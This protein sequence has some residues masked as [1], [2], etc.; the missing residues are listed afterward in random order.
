[1][2]YYRSKKRTLIDL[3]DKL[4]GLPLLHPERPRLVQMICDLAHEV[5]PAGRE[6]PLAEHRLSQVG[7]RPSNYLGE[8]VP[9]DFQTRSKQRVLDDLVAKME[10]L[11]PKHP[12][13]PNLLRTILGL[14]QI[15]DATSAASGPAP[16]PGP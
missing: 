3:V 10:T 12:D 4:D 8:E 15:L 14:R 1:M 7:Q 11:S 5:F 16:D 2:A 9:M 13:R 6:D